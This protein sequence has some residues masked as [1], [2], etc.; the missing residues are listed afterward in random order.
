M[1][2]APNWSVLLLGGPSGTGKTTIAAQV[3]RRL[4]TSWLMV[5]DLRLALMRSGVAIPDSPEIK[6]FDAL[7]VQRENTC[8]G[9][10]TRLCGVRGRAL[11]RSG[12][13]TDRVASGSPRRS[14][15]PK[16]SLSCTNMRSLAVLLGSLIAIGEAVAPA[17][18][19]V[20]ENHVDQRY[21]VVIEG[22]GILPSIFE[23]KSVR[24]RATNGRVRAVYLHE[25][26]PNALLANLVARGA[27]NWREDLRAYAV[28]SAAYGE[29]LK[30][31]AEQRG[32]PTVPARPW[33]TLADRILAASDLSHHAQPTTIHRPVR[34]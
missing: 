30:R 20:I 23:R 11:R 21:P 15:A 26:D 4:G 1:N 27:D 31:E 18:E 7:V 19:V 6:P 13:A 34:K 9:A 25:L 10:T 29:W 24:T 3:A 28:R 12:A 33:D 2:V 32:L 14:P 8:A 16:I 5:D 22:D 17:I